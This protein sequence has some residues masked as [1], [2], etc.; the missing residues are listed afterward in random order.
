M[1]QEIYDALIIGGGPGGS[2]AATYLARAGKRVLVLEKERFPRFHIGESLLPYCQPIFEEMGVLPTLE[3]AGFTKKYGAQF[4]LGNSSKQLKLTF[5]NGRFTRSPEAFQVE[6][7]KFD[8]LLLKHCRS[9]GAEVREGW[10]VTKFATGPDG[11]SVEV[12]DENGASDLIEGSFLIDASGRANLTGN[13]EGLRQNY[14]KLKKLAVFGHFEDVRIDTGRKAG[15]ILIVRL[16]DKWFWLIP[17]SPKKVSVG[18]VMDQ[19]AFT[20]AKQAPAD[21]FTRAFQSSSE[22]RGRMNNAR[23]VSPLQVTSDFSYRN[24]RLIGPRLL[25]IGDAAGFMDPIFSS[26][27]YVAMYSGRLASRAVLASLVAGD[28]GGSRFKAYEKRISSAMDLYWEMIE[29]FYT[30][31]FIELFMEPRRRFQLPDAIVAILAGEL[32]GGWKLRW[33]LRTFFWLVKLHALRPLVPAIL[34]ADKAQS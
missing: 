21:L 11:A 14:P 10:T 2:T 6:R 18:L 16:A 23:P 24:R 9:A 4:H 27:V 28:D 15:D 32:E 20:R 13:H 19:E 30:Q 17:L 26:G 12:R 5:R 33:R 34:F 3:A 8:D 25:R 1:P 7:A 22:M 31:P 29:G